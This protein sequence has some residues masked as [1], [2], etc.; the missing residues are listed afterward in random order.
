[1]TDLAHIPSSSDADRLMQ[2]LL[3][4]ARLETAHAQMQQ[5]LDRITAELDAARDAL[6]GRNG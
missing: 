3:I 4:I 2:A 5:T 6:G 1:M